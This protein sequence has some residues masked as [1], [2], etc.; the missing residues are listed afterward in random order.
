MELALKISQEYGKG[1]LSYSSIKL[2]L[3]DMRLFEMKMRDQLKTKR[4]TTWAQ[5]SGCDCSDPIED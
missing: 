1:Y 2:A 4:L 5:L 3:Q